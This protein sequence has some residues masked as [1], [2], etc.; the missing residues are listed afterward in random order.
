VDVFLP[1]PEQVSFV[2]K[3]HKAKTRKNQDYFVLRVTVPKKVA[4]KLDIQPGDHIFFR[5]KKA[6]WYHMLDWN[7]M[8]TTWSMLPQEIQ[9]K[10]IYEGLPYPGAT[11]Q[12]PYGDIYET[13]GAT[14]PTQTTSALS[15]ELNHV[16]ESEI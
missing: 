5:A 11:D 12:M 16:M 15:G 10:A 6:Q 1:D 8:K 9:R 2:A 7:N 4:K 13:F 14:N 3:A